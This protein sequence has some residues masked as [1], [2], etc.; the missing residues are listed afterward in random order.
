METIDDML[1]KKGE[2]RGISRGEQRG[3]LK[4]CRDML[5]RNINARF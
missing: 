3:E 1:E 5:L 4:K 2:E